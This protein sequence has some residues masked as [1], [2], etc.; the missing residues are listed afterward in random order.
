MNQD[1]T[2]K[3]IGN[4]IRGDVF[5]RLS[6]T[7]SKTS[8]ADIKQISYGKINLGK[9]A[10][11]M[12]PRR[13]REDSPQQTPARNIQRVADDFGSPSRNAF[14][15]VTQSVDRYAFARPRLPASPSRPILSNTKRIGG[16]G[17]LSRIRSR[18]KNGLMSPDRIIEGSHSTAQI[19]DAD[20]RPM[21]KNLLS[22]LERDANARDSEVK[23]SKDILD[24]R[25]DLQQNKHVAFRVP[26]IKREAKQIRKSMRFTP[27][28]R[29]RVADLLLRLT[30][31]QEQLARDI[32]ELREMLLEN[33]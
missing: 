17:S 30:T 24:S 3:D 14:A 15:T 25:P 19:P 6:R 22:Q 20:R 7:N 13:L 28:E 10:I 18:F 1:N 11:R 16:D 4:T 33:D 23:G 8:G 12:S 26:E 2:L 5:D 27:Q 29:R 9:A 31:R 32:H 21:A